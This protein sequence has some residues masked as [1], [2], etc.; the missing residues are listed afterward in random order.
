MIVTFTV[1][2]PMI[3]DARE[4]AVRLAQAQ[5]YARITVLSILRVG[6]GTQWEVKL[7]VMR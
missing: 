6:S 7:Q 5:G 4:Q 2:T 3:H 1:D